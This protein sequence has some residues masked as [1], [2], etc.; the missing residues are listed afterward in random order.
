MEGQIRTVY[1]QAYTM[2]YDLAKKA[3]KAYCFERGLSS[4]N[5]IQFGYWDAGHDGLQAGERL[6]LALK[7]LEMAYQEKRGYDYEITKPISLRQV[8]SLAL[9][10][11]RETGTCEFALPEVLFDMDHPGHYMRRMKSIALT[12]PC[13]VGPYTSMNCTLRLTEHEFRTSASLCGKDGYQ[14]Q[15]DEPDERFSTVNVPI[16]SIAVSTGQ[17]DS[18]VF[19]LNFRDE[20]YIPFEGAGVISKWRI[21]L[22]Q[23]FPQFDYT[24]IA[25][26]IMHLRYTALWG[27]EKL[28]SAANATVKT[29][30]SNVGELSQQEGL[31]AVFDLK[32]DFS[33]EWYKATHSTDHHIMTLE[34]LSDRLPL[35]TRNKTVTAQKV[36]L[37]FPAAY[38]SDQVI[39]MSF[40]SPAPAAGPNISDKVKTFVWDNCAWSMQKWELTLSEQIKDTDKIWLV[41]RYTIT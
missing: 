6:Y 19:E 28:K 15:M 8:N 24:T 30:L 20:R 33:D 22:P 7:Q 34:K 36:L 14:K 12:I 3:E 38:N 37:C 4:S 17:N 23:E 29:Y 16:T 18:G 32:G 9:I 35:F 40:S 11:L 5:F 31:Y 41:I 10:Q 13:V 39:K 26:V 21:E 1:Y 2:A 27:G 25:D